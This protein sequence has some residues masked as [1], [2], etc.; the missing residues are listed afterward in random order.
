MINPTPLH[1]YPANVL[2]ARTPHSRVKYECASFFG[3]EENGECDIYRLIVRVS[4]GYFQ[5]I[6]AADQHSEELFYDRKCRKWA[7]ISVP[8]TDWR[9]PPRASL[10]VVVNK[11]EQ[12]RPDVLKMK[13][14]ARKG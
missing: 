4:D 7:H 8:T 5:I 11:I 2:Y 3:I 1:F 6:N 14:G 12:K 10:V 9:A 13:A